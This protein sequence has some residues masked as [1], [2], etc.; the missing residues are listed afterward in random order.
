MNKN[1]APY[2]GLAQRSNS[3]LYG[4][5]IIKEKIEKV[6]VILVDANASSKYKDRLTSKFNGY[7]LFFIDNMEEV[8][9]KDNVK[10][11]AITQETLANMII[12]ILR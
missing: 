3:V 8:I 7:P 6:R 1:I 9:H 5:D 11:I 2:V 10:S 12:S 4:E